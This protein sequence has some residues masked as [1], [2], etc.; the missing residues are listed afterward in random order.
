VIQRARGR[1]SWS[2]RLS[3]LFLVVVIAAS[4]PSC[5]AVLDGKAVK[6]PP[7]SAFFFAGEVP[8]YGQPVR[9]DDIAR[10]KYL[11]AMRR[12]D[13]CG[14]L[15]GGTLAKIGE[16][17]SVGTTLA[18]DECD[19]ELK[20]SG[21]A[22]RFLSV[23]LATSP[24][25]PLS[26]CGVTVPLPLSALPGAPALPDGM[27]PMVWV[28]LIVDTDCQLERRIGDGLAARLRTVALPPRDAAALYQSP[29][30]ERDPCEVLTMLDGNKA[31]DVF[32]SK[33]YQCRLKVDGTGVVV[34]LQP[35][36]VD[37]RQE[38][39]AAFELVGPPMQRRLIGGGYVNL[40]G[41]VIRPAVAVNDTDGYDCGPVADIASKAALLYR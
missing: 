17:V 16:L 39:C 33:P 25:D 2:R 24:R 6:G 18:F 38:E 11:R 13:V 21:G 40:G 26:F 8:I 35:Q 41:V 27:Q 20:V 34:Q 28:E 9:S 22:R 30:A 32:G 1:I 7:D 29:L 12:I 15:S 19:A 36:Y 37:A 5:S 4:L 14:L 31:W 3:S 10:L 23:T